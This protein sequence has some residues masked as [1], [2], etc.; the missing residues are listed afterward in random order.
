MKR[1]VALVVTM[2]ILVGAQVAG[3][4]T[5]TPPSTPDRPLTAGAMRYGGILGGALLPTGDFSDFGGTGWT[6]GIIGYQFINSMRKIAVGSE[7]GYEAFGKEAGVSVSNFPVNGVVKILFRLE[8]Q[9]LRIF[10]MGGLGFNYTRTDFGKYDETDY[11]FGTLA[12]GGVELHTNGAVAL[13]GDIGYRWVFANP[14]LSYVSLRAGLLI[15]FT[16]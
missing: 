15:P 16:R 4:Q 5:S 3:A 13:M 8:T 11:N 6:I 14:D 9:K 7:V 12:G 10:A 1:C 2:L